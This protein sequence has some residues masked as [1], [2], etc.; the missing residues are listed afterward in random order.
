MKPAGAGWVLVTQQDHD[1][2]F[3]AI[4]SA[5]RNAILT[6]VITLSVVL[7]IA[8][9]LSRRLTGPIQRLTG[10]ANEASLANF[11]ALDT[12]MAEK[13][14]SDEV[15]ELARSVERLAVSLR[16]AIGRLQKKP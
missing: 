9:V 2:A 7:V 3:G 14:R 5:N 11:S 16:V 6:L 15:G 12:D 10:I 13:Y 4:K 1:E 8:Y